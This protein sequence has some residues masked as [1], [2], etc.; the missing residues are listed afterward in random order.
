MKV[1][2]AYLLSMLGGNE[3]PSAAEVKK[4]LASVGMELDGDEDQRLQSLVEEMAGKSMAEVMKA[5][6]EKLS[7]VPGGGS[8]GGAVAA[9]P[10]VSGDAP[11]AG[12]APAGDDK[13]D[14]DDDD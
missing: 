4:V 13:D 14:D 8:G 3:K 11:A 6:H 5:G 1:I 2:A 9:A 12:D 7:K 10:G